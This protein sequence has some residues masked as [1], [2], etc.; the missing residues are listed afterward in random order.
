MSV[1]IQE[2][3]QHTR[4]QERTS[5][6]NQEEAPRP[7]LLQR[8]STALSQIEWR[9]TLITAFVMSIGW[10]ILFLA[11]NPILQL[12]VGVVPVLGGLFLGRRVQQ[13]LLLHGLILGISGFF[14]GLVVVAGYASLG[15]VGAVPPPQM[16]IEQGQPPQTLSVGQAVFF[17]LSF[18][19]LAMIPFPA[20]GT[21]MAGRSEQRQRELRRQI[22][23]RGGR[24]ERPGSVRTL[25][26]LRGLSL[27]QLGSYIINLFKKKGFEFKDYRFIDKDKH[28]DVELVYQEEIYLIRMSVADKVRSGTVE[29]LVQDMKRRDIHKGLVITSTEFMPDV[30]KAAKGR[31]NIVVVDGQTL[32]DMAEN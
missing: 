21:V 25:E 12:L 1:D 27:P 10:C 4:E 23:E 6:A 15:Q 7:S 11:N 18:S 2:E 13:Q 5:N 17:Y 30:M 19:L 8:F 28:L 20:F 9:V 32:F 14:I 24:L 16:T 26:D 29:S 22:E 31:R 3:Q